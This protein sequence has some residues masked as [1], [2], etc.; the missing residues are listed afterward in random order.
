MKLLIGR[1]KHD[2][3]MML[4]DTDTLALDAD[5]VTINGKTDTTSGIT[6]NS[7]ELLED[8]TAEAFLIDINLGTYRWHK[9]NN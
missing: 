5:G 6:E 1:E 7:Y 3:Y 2:V 4:A 8:V 9:T